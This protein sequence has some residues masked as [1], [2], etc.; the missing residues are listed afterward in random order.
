MKKII[1]ILFLFAA[2]VCGIPFVSAEEKESFTIFQTTDIHGAVGD[3]TNPGLLQVASEIRRQRKEIGENTLWI[4]CGDLMQGTPIAASDQGASMINALSTAGCDIF[5]PGNHDFDYGRETLIRNLNAFHGTVLGAN[6]KINGYDKLKP[7]TL[8]E[9]GKYR[10]AVIGIVTPF[11]KQLTRRTPEIL[12][13]IEVTSAEDALK[14]IMPDIM[15]KEPNVIVLAIHLG[16]YTGER[17]TG[18]GKPIYLSAFST[19]YPQIDLILSGHSHSTVAGKSLTPDAWLAQAPYQ[20]K[21]AVK[22]DLK[23]KPGERK[24]VSVTSKL[25]G[26]TKETPIDE[27]LQKIFAPTQK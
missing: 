11:L 2:F 25:L 17:M 15:K 9:R 22:V 6:L 5:V 4:D 19:D 3:K 13:G 27:D 24:K 18:T 8:I 14:S 12:E 1:S 16:E 10:I 21:D 20:G 26:V 23:L 7:W